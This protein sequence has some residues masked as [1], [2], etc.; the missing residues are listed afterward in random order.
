MANKRIFI[1]FAIEDE[2]IR[3]LLKGQ[4]LNTLTPFE[5]TD[6]SVKEPWST[7]WKEQCRT[8]I[9]SCNGV[10]ALLSRNSLTATG[11]RWEIQCAVEERVPLIGMYIYKDDRS[12][13]PEMAGQRTTTWTWDA[14]AAFINSL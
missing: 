7:N 2:R 4:S 10:I 5:Y 8:R 3:D 9:R 6:M 12:T 11:Q 13:P 1:A 14:I